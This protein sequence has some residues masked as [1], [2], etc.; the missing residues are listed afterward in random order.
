MLFFLKPRSI[1]WW[2]LFP[3]K[4]RFGGSAFR[5]AHVDGLVW[6][7]SYSY[8]FSGSNPLFMASTP[9][10]IQR[11]FGTIHCRRFNGREMGFL[12]FYGHPGPAN[13][14]PVH[15]SSGHVPSEVEVFFQ[16][17]SGDL[18]L[19]LKIAIYSEFSHSTWW[20]SILK[21]NYQ[22]VPLNQGHRKTPRR[23]VFTVFGVMRFFV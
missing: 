3:I 12:S 5:H 20:I 15:P 19:L 2:I 23:S 22:R 18:T 7:Q 13:V 4:L 9:L 21:L 6:H 1:H 17:P 14:H 16:L 10:G 11:F 8:P